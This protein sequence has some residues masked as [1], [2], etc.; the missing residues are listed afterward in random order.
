MNETLA[1]Y[2]IRTVPAYPLGEPFDGRP[3]Y[4]MT[5]EQARVYR[6]LVAN[7]PHFGEFQLCFT[8]LCDAIGIERSTAHKHIVSL[9]ERGWLEHAPNGGH[10]R[11]ALVQPVRVFKE[12]HHA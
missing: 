2:A 11:Y 1:F 7:R 9:V 10:T 6:W 3:R 8:D 4:G 12:P 5:P